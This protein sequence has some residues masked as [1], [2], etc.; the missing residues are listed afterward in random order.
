MNLTTVDDPTQRKFLPSFLRGVAE[1]NKLI[2]SPNFVVTQALVAL[3]A[4]KGARLRPGPDKA[5]VDKRGLIAHLYAHPSHNTSA[6]GPLE[7]ANAL[8]ACCLSSRLSS[9][10]R[11]W[12]A[13]QLVRTLAAHDRDNQSRPQTFADMAGDLRKSSFIKLEAHQSRVITCGWCTKKGLL[14]TSGNDGTV[15]VWSVT[16][17]QYTL[18]QTCVFRKEYVRSF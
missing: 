2:T 4:D 13:Q 3:L 8:A 10:H 1:E 9:Q 11:Q 5:D 15:R 12:A 14:A 7:L 17:S 18:Q 16:K 6:V